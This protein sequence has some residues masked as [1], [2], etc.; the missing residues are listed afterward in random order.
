MRSGSRSGGGR[1]RV[2]C[3]PGR[4]RPQSSPSS[5]SPT[6]TRPWRFSRGRHRRR[7]LRHDR[8]TPAGYRRRPQP[9][10]CQRRAGQRRAV[11]RTGRQ[12]G[13]DPGPGRAARP[14]RPGDASR[15]ARRLRRAR[16]RPDA[17]A[18]F[19]REWRAARARAAEAAR[20][21]AE[22]RAEEICCG[23]IR[24]SSTRCRRRATRR[25]GS[26]HAAPCCR[27]PS[28]SA[29]RSARRSARSTAKGARN[30]RWPARL[31]RL[32]RARDRAQGLLDSAMAAAERAA[33]G[34]RRGAGRADRRGQALEL[35]PRALEE[36]EE[37]LFALRA[38]GPQAR[39]QGRR[40]A[41][42]ARASRQGL[43]RSKRRR[44][45]HRA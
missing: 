9:R 43:R 4:S 13:R 28:G 1:R 6:I 35:D 20:L 16:G 3:G 5:R 33:A 26:P 23:T 39:H 12:P 29:R 34:N 11:A 19:W 27:T 25:S 21:L 17:L 14:V 30:G 32:E 40:F 8:A 2:W 18:A 24:P 45:R 31:R 37:R 7:S 15:A 36:V 22:S 10:L 38:A 44:G 42:A 41:A